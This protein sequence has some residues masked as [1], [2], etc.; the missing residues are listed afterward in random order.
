MHLDHAEPGASLAS[1][2]ASMDLH[3]THSVATASSHLYEQREVPGKGIGTFAI[4]PI[5]AG[6]RVIS[7]APLFAIHE[8]ADILE[9]YRT[10]K[11]L[12]DEDSS[13]FWALAASTRPMRDPKWIEEL[14][15]SYEGGLFHA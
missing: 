1:N 8:D 7:E 9:V 2:L 3:N 13:R 12:S 5:A 14:Q 10:V 15:S 11:A 6:A 4:A